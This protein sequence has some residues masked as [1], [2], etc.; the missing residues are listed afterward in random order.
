MTEPHSAFGLECGHI[1]NCGRREIFHEAFNFSHPSN[2]QTAIK[3][4]ETCPSVGE[5]WAAANVTSARSTL[6]G[7]HLS[8]QHG[9]KHQDLSFYK[10]WARSRIA[11]S[12]DG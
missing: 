7:R 6:D 10:Q 9:I 8:M 5:E 3:T 11:Q 4:S 1:D 2:G 12:V